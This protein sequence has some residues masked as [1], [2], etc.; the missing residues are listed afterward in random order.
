MTNQTDTQSLTGVVDDLQDK[1]AE[2]G[3]LSVDDALDEFAGRLFGPLL[4]L[5]GFVT[6][7]PLG[8][9]PTVPTL[10]ALLVIL[11][12]GQLL[13][14]LQHPWVPGFLA[15]RSVDEER[16]RR[17]VE[18]SRS[19]LTWVDRLTS[20]RLTWLVTG[21]MKYAIAAVCTLVALMLPPLEFLPMACM[22]PGAALL[23]LGLAI[24]AKDGLL[25]ILGLGFTAG[26]AYLVT[27]AWST[28]AG[29]AGLG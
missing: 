23:L 9:I 21:P 7:S 16:Y 6:L 2:D 26:A 18:K 4:M 24:T 28:F 8:Y 14:G 11:V 13:V 20:Q 17:A 22:A 3:D 19:W 5:P 10:M 12:T 1:A 27:V 15:S 25:A 29:W